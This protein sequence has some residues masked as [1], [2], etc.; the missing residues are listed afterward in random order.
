METFE[1]K[2][3]RNLIRTIEAEQSHLKGRASR[4]INNG[5]FE[6]LAETADELARNAEALRIYTQDLDREAQRFYKEM[7]DYNALT[8][9]RINNLLQD[10][11]TRKK[12]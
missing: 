12:L 5:E 2:R 9:E 10:A 11:E 6:R 8:V 1:Y 4:E 7:N 3:I